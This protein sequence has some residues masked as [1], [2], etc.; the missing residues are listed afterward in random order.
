MYKYNTQGEF[1][2][3]RVVSSLTKELE[4]KNGKLTV[5]NTI[6]NEVLDENSEFFIGSLTKVFTIIALLILHQKGLIDLLNDKLG[7]YIKN[8]E[9]EDLKLIDI[10][11]HESGLISMPNGIYYKHYKTANEVYDTFKNENLL[12][13]KN[14]KGKRF[15]SNVGYIIL[16]VVIENVSNLKY[17]DFILNEI[18]KPLNM[19]NTGIEDSNLKLYDK[20]GKELNEINR[21]TQEEKYIN[22][23]A[24]SAGQL[25]SSVKD[26]KK[27]INFPSLLSSESK[28][29]LKKT[30]IYVPKEN[31]TFMF[32]HEGSIK[33]GISKFGVKFNNNWNL[34]DYYIYLK[35]VEEFKN[36]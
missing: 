17:S 5:K 1:I 14:V 19:E 22:Y 15:Y 36:N 8:K 27:F 24:T 29:I 7:K 25:K 34:I 18:T 32:G 10:V 23:W 2:I 11:N 16:G 35:T 26:L 31:N 20:Y 30:Y 21:I 12:S 13:E 3:N 33:G 9:I 6:D 4:Y 28:E